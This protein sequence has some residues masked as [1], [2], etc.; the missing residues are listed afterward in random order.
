MYI[1]REN[2]EEIFK[3]FED[4]FVSALLGPRRV[5]K[6]TLVENYIAAYPERKWVKFNMDERQQRQ[7]IDNTE[8]LLMIE[9]LSLQKVGD[10]EK[11][12]VVIDEAQKCPELLVTIKKIVDKRR[13][14]GRFLLSG[15]A[16]FS[17]LKGI[18]E[19]LAGRALYLTL[20]PFTRREITQS[21]KKTPFLV[22]FIQNPSVP[23]FLKYDPI[24]PK[25]II[26][27]GMPPVC[28]DNQNHIALWFKGYEQT[29]LER[30]IRTVHNIGSL[31]DF[32]LFLRL[33]AAI[34]GEFFFAQY[35][36]NK[37][38]YTHCGHWPQPK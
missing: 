29:Y 13:S 38:Y 30:D 16:N 35:L 10:Q 36:I 3:S 8:L 28:L 22:N 25:E 37:N 7:R 18:T 33:L 31:R 12:W 26:T 19:S 11:L 20:S 15:S 23:P 4:S 6:T 21:I 9:E 17:L 2:E 27:G 34:L 1:L 5:G 24:R 14:P 32:Q